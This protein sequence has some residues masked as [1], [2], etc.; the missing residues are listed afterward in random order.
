MLTGL[1]QCGARRYL[2]RLVPADLVE[3]WGAGEVNRA[4]G[5]SNCRVA[6]AIL[7]RAWD[8][9]DD[10]FAPMRRSA[11]PLSRFEGADLLLR[12]RAATPLRLLH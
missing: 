11:N 2:R 3:S 12:L 6:R 10:E 9:L 5:T 4:L 1:K 7:P 8:D